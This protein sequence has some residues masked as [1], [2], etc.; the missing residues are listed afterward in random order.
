[1]STKMGKFENI[2]SNWMSSWKSKTDNK[3]ES[4]IKL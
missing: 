4:T 3:L 1:M 2:P